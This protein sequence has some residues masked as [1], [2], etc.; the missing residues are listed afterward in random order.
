[1]IYL[2]DKKTGFG[3]KCL[4]TSSDYFPK[5]RWG[6]SVVR[7]E[8]ITIDGEVCRFYYRGPNTKYAFFQLNGRAYRMLIKSFLRARK[9]ELE[10]IEYDDYMAGER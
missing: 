4:N 5:F 10:K 2:R 3:Y 8:E 1:M 9:G 6:R 7:C